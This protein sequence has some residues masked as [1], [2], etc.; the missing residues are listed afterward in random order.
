VRQSRLGER[1]GSALGIAHHQADDGAV[2]R[3][4][5]RQRD[6]PVVTGLE[7]ADNAKQSPDAI[8]H[9]HIEL[10]HSR[11]V[12]AACGREADVGA[13]VLILTVAHDAPLFHCGAPGEGIW[14]G[15]PPIAVE[16]WLL[17]VPSLGGSAVHGNTCAGVNSTR[18]AEPGQPPSQPP[19]RSECWSPPGD[20]CPSRRDPCRLVR[21]GPSRERT[22]NA[23][24]TSGGA[25]ER[26]GPSSVDST[27]GQV[28]TSGSGTDHGNRTTDPPMQSEPNTSQTPFEINV[29]DRVRRLPPYL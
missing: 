19:P 8:G 28:Y 27:P 5:H 14:E 16:R 15:R 29:A 3:I 7:A 24:S 2:G 11:P 10:A 21:Q 13:G 4:D 26:F 20:M 6:N 9:E 23:T 22:D 17:S 25:G 1:F 18:A 12:P